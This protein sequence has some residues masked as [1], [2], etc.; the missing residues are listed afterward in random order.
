MDELTACV[1]TTVDAAVDKVFTSWV[2][3]DSLAVWFWP[4][5]AAFDVDLS[6][7]GAFHYSSAALGVA[8]PFSGDRCATPACLYLD[9]G[10]GI[11]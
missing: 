9:L 1:R 7:G 3:P 10:R 11:R 2:S 5:P 8:G 4:F 6:V